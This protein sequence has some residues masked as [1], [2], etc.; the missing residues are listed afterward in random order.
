MF[1][2]RLDLGLGWDGKQ[3]RL[4]KFMNKKI[5]KFYLFPIEITLWLHAG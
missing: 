1:V 4:H 3:A 2:Y 5:D